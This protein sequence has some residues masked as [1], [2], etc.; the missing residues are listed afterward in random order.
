[1]YN[2]S[3]YI[4]YHGSIYIA[5]TPIWRKKT[6]IRETVARVRDDDGFDVRCSLAPDEILFLRVSGTRTP[7]TA[8]THP[9]TYPF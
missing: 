6:R 7:A 9:A 2:N 4:I 3:V 5:R 8:H 1:M